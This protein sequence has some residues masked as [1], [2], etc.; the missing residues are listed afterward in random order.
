M[1][2]WWWLLLWAFVCGFVVLSSVAGVAEVVKARTRKARVRDGIAAN[3]DSSAAAKIASRAIAAAGWWFLIMGG[4]TWV[5]G[6][7][8]ATANNRRDSAYRDIAVSVARDADL[9]PG[10]VLALAT[11]NSQQVRAVVADRDDLSEQAAV[12]LAED[13]DAKI[14]AL[15]AARNGLPEPVIVTL[16][17]DPD[18]T[19]RAVVAARADLP[20]AAIVTL[21]C[22]PEPDIRAVAAAGGVTATAAAALAECTPTERVAATNPLHISERRS[23]I[24]DRDVL[25]AHQTRTLGSRL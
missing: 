11:S 10:A 17:A 14:R 3:V 1:S 8:L 9:A 24:P 13:P 2:I 22:D 15:I 12:T 20:D 19:V 6:I 25:R 18:A 5:A 21:M 4:F 23:Q 16:A 7:A